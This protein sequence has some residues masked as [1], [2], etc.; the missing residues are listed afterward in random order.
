MGY[1]LTMIRCFLIG[2]LVLLSGCLNKQE[3]DLTSIKSEVAAEERAANQAQQDSQEAFLV[4]ANRI[5]EM[6]KKCQEKDKQA[7]D[8]FTA[9]TYPMKPGAAGYEVIKAACE[10]N[11]SNDACYSLGSGLLEYGQREEAIRFFLIGCQKGDETNCAQ[12]AMENLSGN[13]QSQTSQAMSDVCKQK[14]QFCHYYYRFQIQ[15]GH[16]EIGFNNLDTACARGD[17]LSCMT[18]VRELEIHKPQSKQIKRY[19]ATACQREHEMACH[20]LH[21]LK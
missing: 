15:N 8:D 7:C 4:N 6:K 20:E 13:L 5:E 1:D 10:K 21:E 2:S 3:D 9:Y 18:A 19:L 17:N 11:L 12:V 16:K 14:A